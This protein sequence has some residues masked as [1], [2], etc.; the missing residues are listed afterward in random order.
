ML[1]REE[2]EKRVEARNTEKRETERK[3]LYAL[4]KNDGL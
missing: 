1:G 3:P 4:L 2:E